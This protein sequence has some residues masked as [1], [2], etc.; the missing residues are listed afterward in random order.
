M[1]YVITLLTLIFMASTC[2]A[3]TDMPPVQVNTN[4]YA[5]YMHLAKM[6][7][8]HG[9]E[10]EAHATSFRAIAYGFRQAK[11]EGVAKE[12]EDA[13][14]KWDEFAKECKA[15]SEDIDRSVRVLLRATEQQY[16]N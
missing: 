16:R 4:N 5:I 1:K 10:A 8:V 15:N 9:Q 14:K 7:R 3:D 11:Q 2:M 12:Y 6:Y 13:A